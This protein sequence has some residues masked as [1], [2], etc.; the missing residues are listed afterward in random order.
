MRKTMS[1][2]LLD[3]AIEQTRFYYDLDV[4]FEDKDVHAYIGACRAA[5]AATEYNTVMCDFLAS[6][7]SFHGLKN[8]AT[9][10]DVYK[11]LEVLGWTVE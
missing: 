2:V 9:N 4:R 8:D 1:K 10:E 3:K 5:Y 7:F 6:L 11:V